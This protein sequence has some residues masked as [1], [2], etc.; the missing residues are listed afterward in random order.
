MKQHLLTHHSK[1]H[2]EYIRPAVVKGLSEGKK[3]NTRV[4]RAYL[5]EQDRLH[6]VS[7]DEH[8]K[9]PWRGSP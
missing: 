6:G 5:L 4:R 7:H 2:R 1:P 8:N 9:V 3:K